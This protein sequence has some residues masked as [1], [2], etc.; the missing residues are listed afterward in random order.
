MLENTGSSE[1]NGP[2]VCGSGPCLV[3]QYRGSHYAQLQFGNRKE[4]SLLMTR[5]VYKGRK[6]VGGSQALVKLFNM[7]VLPLMLKV[8]PDSS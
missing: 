5:D 7:N 3:P 8:V 4:R 1:E 6:F 2:V